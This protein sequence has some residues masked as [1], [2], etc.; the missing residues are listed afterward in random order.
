M[1]EI[2]MYGSG[3]CD[4][5]GDIFKKRY[6]DEGNEMEPPLES[7]IPR[8][9]NFNISLPKKINKIC[10]GG[11][12]TLALTNYG[13]VYSWGSADD[14]SLGRKGPENTPIK[15]DIPSFILDITAGDC[16]GVAYNNILNQIYWWGSFRNVNGLFSKIIESPILFD[17]DKLQNQEVKKIKSGANHIVFLT[18]LNRVFCVGN[19]EFGQIGRDPTFHI[20]ADSDFI[21][22]LFNEENIEDIFTGYNHSFLLQ[23]IDDK[24]ILKAWGRNTWGQ[25]GIGEYNNCYIP[26]IVKFPNLA[27]TEVIQCTGGENHSLA[28]TNNYQVYVWGDN[29]ENQC[30]NLTG[31]DKDNNFTTP[32][33]LEFFNDNLVTEIR[34]NSYYNYAFNPESG[35]VYSWGMG[36]FLTLGNKTY[37][38]KISP[39]LIPSEF[40]RGLGITDISLGAHHVATLLRDPSMTYVKEKK[41]ENS[42][43]VNPPEVKTE[44][45]HYNNDMRRRDDNDDDDN[46]FPFKYIKTE[47]IKEENFNTYNFSFYRNKMDIEYDLNNVPSQNNYIGILPI[48]IKN[49]DDNNGFTYDKI[50]YSNYNNTSSEKKNL[51]NNN[52]LN[53]NVN[54]IINTEQ[55]SKKKINVNIRSNIKKSSNKKKLRKINKTKEKSENKNL[56]NSSSKKNNKDNDKKKETKNNTFHLILRST[57]KKN[58]SPSKKKTSPSKTNTKTNQKTKEEPKFLIKV[59]KFLENEEIPEENN[60]HVIQP[61]E[62]KSKK[63]DKTIKNESKSIKN[64]NNNKKLTNKKE[65][66]NNKKKSRTLS[67]PNKRKKLS[68]NIKIKKEPELR[69]STRL[70]E[71]KERKK[72]NEFI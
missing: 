6:D 62:N 9:L 64:K 61:K 4:Q 40:F 35:K 71:K 50:K 30:G 51:R 7:K 36:E 45:V 48:N 23:K 1:E 3:E 10:C 46:R 16:H 8:K 66:D 60:L 11:M 32:R 21:P 39:E 17:N 68:V 67:K 34:S 38:N 26:K 37:D 13:E 19:G 31:A 49:N 57:V 54:I 41:F 70:K 42:V 59:N 24:K 58:N 55:K 72:F 63:K 28:L 12:F 18:K 14:G 53:N 25:L 33:L 65:K 15:L 56:R 47:V 44:Y 27:E 29:D 69:R 22:N 2:Y 5:L 43:N 20:V 52:N